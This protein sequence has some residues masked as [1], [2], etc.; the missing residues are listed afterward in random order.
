MMAAVAMLIAGCG[1][2]PEPAKPAA[3]TPATSPAPV[4]QAAGG[5][6]PKAGN[7]ACKTS[8][9]AE[10]NLPATEVDV[11]VA[12]YPGAKVV[13]A[14]RGTGPDGSIT[15]AQQETSDPPEKVLAFYRGQLKARAPGRDITDNGAPDANGTAFLELD[16][17]G[18]TIQITANGN[19]N[20]TSVSIGTVCGRK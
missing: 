11:G 5:A 15:V 12:F 17:D 19:S 7:A 3:P 13:Q 6:P 14:T 8:P 1:K 10:Q 16:A 20:G 2:A 9:T 18:T 4:A